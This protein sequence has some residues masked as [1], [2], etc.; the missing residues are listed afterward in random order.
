MMNLRPFQIVLLGTFTFLAFLSLIVLSNTKGTTNTEELA[1]GERVVIWGSLDDDMF[2]I[3]FR[4]ITQEDKA[5]GVVEYYQIDER[6]FD[7]EFINAIAEGRSPDMI[8]LPAESLVKHRAKLLAIPDDSYPYTSYRN[9]FVDGSEIYVLRDGIYALPFAVDPILLFWNRDIFASNGLAQ[10]PRTWEEIVANV[11]PRITQRD[12]SRN[13]LRSSIA[14]GEYRNVL[15]AKEVLMMLALQS[16]SDMVTDGER[17]YFLGI[18][19]SSAGGRAPLEA[20]LQFYTDF[21]NA[22]SPTYSWNRAMPTDKNAFVSGDLALYFGY[23][24]EAENINNKN[25]NLNFDVAQVP[26]GG[27]ATALRTYGTFYGFAIPRA[28]GNINGAFNV[29]QKLTS[30]QVND[31][32]TRALNMASPRRDVVAVGDSSPYRNNM[33]QSALIARTWL[34]PDPEASSDIFLR[35]VEDVVSNRSR[36]GGAVGDAINRLLLEY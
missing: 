36:A 34:D 27:T 23:G 32:L 12:N 3:V 20:S 10:A 9:N 30:A 31:E 16:G 29:A 1:Y 5:F 24:S 15:Q 7:D 4:N 6:N 18:N 25:P 2:D 14:F 26:Q 11:V 19:Q 35:M 33:L 22:N 8:V 17:G 21:S 13:I 28:S